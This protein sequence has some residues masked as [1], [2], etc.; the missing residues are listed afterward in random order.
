MLVD[1]VDDPAESP[2][3]DQIAVFRAAIAAGKRAGR[4]ER[5]DRP[6]DAQLAWQRAGELHVAAGDT[7]RGKTASARAAGR[8]RRT[9]GALPLTLDPV[10]ADLLAPLS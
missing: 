1:I 6:D 3:P 2:T 10:V 7:W 9:D 5:L 8:F 4:L